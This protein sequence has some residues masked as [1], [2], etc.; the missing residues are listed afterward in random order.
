MFDVFDAN[1]LVFNCEIIGE[2]NTQPKNKDIFKRKE[3]I[4]LNLENFKK[5][6]TYV[7]IIL[8]GDGTVDKY[9]TEANKFFIK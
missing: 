3:K 8:N 9:R 1:A 7:A 5:M 2:C 4:K 6:D